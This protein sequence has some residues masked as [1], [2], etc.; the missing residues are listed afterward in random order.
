[1]GVLEGHVRR[2]TEFLCSGVRP[3]RIADDEM[4][5]QII[6]ID[7]VNPRAASE[8]VEKSQPSS[9]EHMTR[10]VRGELASGVQSA[11]ESATIVRVCG[12]SPL[13]ARERGMGQGER[14]GSGRD[15]LEVGKTG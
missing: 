15:V 2:R 7:V 6:C 3:S 13:R 12:Q 5:V 14:D 4:A 9:C 11:A 1:M 8:P 10:T